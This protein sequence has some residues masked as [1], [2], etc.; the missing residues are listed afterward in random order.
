[1]SAHH[2]GRGSHPERSEGAHDAGS[3]PLR[4]AQGD[5]RRYPDGDFLSD[6]PHLPRRRRLVGHTAHHDHQADGRGRDAGSLG[7]GRGHRLQDLPQRPLLLHPAR[8]D[9]SGALL[10]VEA[11]PCRGRGSR[12]RTAP[13]CTC[14]SGPASTRPRASSSSTCSASSPARPIGRAQQ[15]LERVKAL[16]QQDGLFD[17]GAQAPDA[18][19]RRHAGRGHERRGRRAA[20][21]DHRGA[22][23]LAVRAR[24]G[25]QRA[26][27]GRRRRRGTGAGAP[28]G[29]PPARGGRLHPRPRRRG[30]R[31]SGG[32]Q[33][34]GGVPRPRRGPRA[35]DLRGGARD[36]HLAHRPRGRP[37]RA[38]P[39]RRGRARAPGPGARSAARSTISPRDSPAGS[40]AVRGSASSGSSA[41]ATGSTRR[42]ARCST[43]IAIGSR[44]SRRSST[45]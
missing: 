15:E 20:R 27:S 25:P 44:G 12:P 41:P 9:V 22:A 19:A 24:A 37:P 16:L 1:M 40:G 33:R 36:R 4:F 28:T 2:P 5:I 31:G 42:W 35:D 18:Q 29:E 11:R 17:P 10:P 45:R 30:P 6:G 8:L 26:R 43:V 13:R 3:W 21:R 32:V 34:G 23:P 14:W 38:D 39:V 7:A